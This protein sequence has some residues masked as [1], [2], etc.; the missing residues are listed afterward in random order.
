MYQNECQEINWNASGIQSY[1]P[2]TIETEREV[3]KII[4]LQNI[5]NNLPKGFTDY[6]GVTKSHNPAVNV[7]ERVGVPTQ[8]LP[9][10]NKR[11]RNTVT[12]DKPPQ[13]ARKPTS[14]MVNEINITLIDTN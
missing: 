7:P 9:N 3:Q 8:N 6:K 1:D 2:R 13:K 4:N 10:Q 14:K 5:E 12:K 11:G